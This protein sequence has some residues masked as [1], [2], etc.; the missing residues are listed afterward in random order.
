MAEQIKKIEKIDGYNKIK[1]NGEIFDMNDVQARVVELLHEA[2]PNTMSEDEIM[3]ILSK[4]FTVEQLKVAM[5][6]DNG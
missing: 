5:G 1:W 6:R 4:E 2:H 3:E